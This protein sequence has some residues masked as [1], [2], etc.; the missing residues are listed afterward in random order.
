M[1]IIFRLLAALALVALGL[2]LW[3]VLF[4]SPEKII[5]KRIAALAAAA[6]FPANEGP[7]VIASGA[8][9]LAAYFSLDAQIT[10]DAPGHGQQTFSGRDEIQQAALLARKA[11]GSLKVEFLDLSVML[12]PDKQNATVDLTAKGQVRG[13]ASFYIQE[14]KFTLKK[15]EGKWLIVRIETVKTLSFLLPVQV[16][17][18]A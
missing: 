7:L 14:M 15:I 5:R 12:S 18:V 6:S 17:R 9:K 16:V 11:V 4:P 8:A 13:E 1:K 2:W 3:S 10:F